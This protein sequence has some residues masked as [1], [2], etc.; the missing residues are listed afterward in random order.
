MPYYIRD[1]KRDHNF[2]NQPYRSYKGFQ[3]IGTWRV[4]PSK[5]HVERTPETHWRGLDVP[6]LHPADEVST[7]IACAGTGII[8]KQKP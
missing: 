7:A 2:D 8:A 1:P 5:D 3:Y 4:G 6:A